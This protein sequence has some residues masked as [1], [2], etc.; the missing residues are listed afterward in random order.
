MI[1]SACN[2]MKIAAVTSAA[3][4]FVGGLL[5]LAAQQLPLETVMPATFTS[6]GFIFI[7]TGIVVMFG[8]VI[9][10]ML[11]HVSRQLDLCQH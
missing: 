7:I 2:L 6:L 3:F 5:V 10:V 9:A 11:P 1:K 8:T 4:I